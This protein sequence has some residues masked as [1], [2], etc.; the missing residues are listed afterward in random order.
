MK[1]NAIRIHEQGGVEQMKFEPIELAPPKSGEACVRHESIGVN[2]IDTY[3]RSGL[4]KLPM[5]SGIGVEAAGVVEEIGAN[6]T[7][8][9]RGD[10]V[11]YCGGA[12]GAYSEAANVPAAR[13][14]RLP[15]A[16]SC[17]AAA[18]MLLKGLTVQYLFRQTYKLSRGETIL[19]HAAAGGVGLIACQ[20]ARH[21]GVTMIGTTSSAEKAKLATARGCAHVINYSTEDFVRRVLELTDGKKVPVVYDGVG[22]DTFIGSLDCL[23][24]RGL[25]V[26]FGNSSGAVTGVDLGILSAKGSLYV[27]RPTLATYTATPQMLR[28]AAAELFD[29]VAQGAIT[30]DITR[31]YKLSE[32]AD[33]HRALQAR[34]TVGSILLTP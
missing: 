18:A 6:V 29:L 11:G 33:A 10:R 26:S 19:F 34:G 3:H 1:I 13:L 24:P 28:S 25:L 5:P 32:A 14:I 30:P 9:K 31:H 23:A 7:D 27:T 20:W 2:Y 8:L 12:M 21:L 22:K 17:D 15:D 16:V 4:Y